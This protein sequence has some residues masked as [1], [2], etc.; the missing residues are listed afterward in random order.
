MLLAAWRGYGGCE[1]LAI[2]NLLSGRRE[3]IGCVLYTTIDRAEARRRS[4][5]AG[6]RRGSTDP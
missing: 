2:P 1:V 5:A 3:E 6:A 4:R